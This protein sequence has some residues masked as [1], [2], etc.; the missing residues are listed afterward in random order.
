MRDEAR[1][2]HIVNPILDSLNKFIQNI[3]HEISEIGHQ[4]LLDFDKYSKMVQKTVVTKKKGSNEN[5]DT[6]EEA[7]KN[8]EGDG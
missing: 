1:T 5:L 3:R 2:A 4:K 7:L 6:I 8:I